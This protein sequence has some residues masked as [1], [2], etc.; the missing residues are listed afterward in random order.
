MLVST[1][2]T[3]MSPIV[4]QEVNHKYF[5]KQQ[6]VYYYLYKLETI[7]TM[8]GQYLVLL[9]LPILY[10]SQ[11]ITLSDAGHHSTR[12]RCYFHCKHNQ[13]VDYFYD[14]VLDGAVIYAGDIP[15]W[16]IEQEGTY[17]EY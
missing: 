9:Y 5:T 2:T 12:M 16:Y 1:L 11:Y 6:K 4:N 15:F 10:S 17:T 14:L 13:V 7:V 3:V 8:N